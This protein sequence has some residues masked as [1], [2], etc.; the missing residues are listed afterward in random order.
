MTGLLAEANA[1]GDRTFSGRMFLALA[2]VV[3]LSAGMFFLLAHRWT[4]HRR[5]LAL[6][7]WA[8]S[9]GFSMSSKG[10]CPEPLT[11]V[12]LRVTLCLSGKDTTL[13]EMWTD[14]TP[15][16]KAPQQPA[17]W[18]V[19]MR[20]VPGAWAAT[21]LRPAANATS[22][23]DLMPLSSY[24][25]LLPPERFMVFGSDSAEAV[26]LADSHLPGLLPKEVGLLLS[27]G[28]LMLDFSSRPFDELEMGRMVALGE[29]IA[30]NVPGRPG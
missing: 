26:A 22:V 23:I 19:L 8:K 3:L 12:A 27:G 7:E 14:T 16:S 9:A 28:W 1:L 5:R 2:A 20:P 25:S 30:A 15:K 13:I 18:H 10:Q 21:G 6:A 17:R 11:G 4:R 24:P 29:Q